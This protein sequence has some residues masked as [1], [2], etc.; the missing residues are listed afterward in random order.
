MY[1]VPEK[2]IAQRSPGPDPVVCY[3]ACQLIFTPASVGFIP[4]HSLSGVRNNSIKKSARYPEETPL[5]PDLPDRKELEE[6]SERFA[7]KY[8]LAVMNS[9]VAHDFLRANR[10]SNIHL[11]PDDW[12]N[13]PIPDA[14]PQEQGPI[15]SLVD[16][17]LDIKSSNPLVDVSTLE[18]KVD[19]LISNL[20]GRA[21]ETVR[22]EG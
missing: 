3:D 18:D 9:T 7:L 13:L 10:R 4:W 8:I 2:I 17:I 1:S 15:A 12:K 19:I 16:Q 20:Y 5:R 14:T 22:E 11:Y 6:T 21:P